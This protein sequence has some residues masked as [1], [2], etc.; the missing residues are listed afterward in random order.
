MS[1]RPQAAEALDC[2]DAALWLAVGV[3]G[4]LL[5]YPEL[6]FLGQANISLYDLCKLELFFLYCEPCLILV[7]FFGGVVA[8]TVHNIEII[9]IDHF[10]F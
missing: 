3:L 2:R 8:L 7:F 5:L 10:Y 6:N 9:F 4:N 1:F